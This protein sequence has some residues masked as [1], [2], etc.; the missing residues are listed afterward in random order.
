LRAILDVNSR[1]K[2][3]RHHENPSFAGE[4]S[5]CVQARDTTLV[6]AKKN[7]KCGLYCCLRS[8]SLIHLPRPI[9][10]DPSTWPVCRFTGLVTIKVENGFLRND[11]SSPKS[12]I[13]L[14]QKTTTS[15]N[16]R[17]PSQP[18]S[19]W[20]AVPLA[21]ALAAL[22][23]L[24]KINASMRSVPAEIAQL[25]PH[26]W[27]KE[28]IR[29]TYERLKKQP[30][31]FDKLLPPRLNRR[32]VVVGGSGETSYLTLHLTPHNR[33]LCILTNA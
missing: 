29:E 21:V 17:T 9:V 5:E 14:E 2:H 25:S 31:G 26:R 1:S 22:L 32:Y 27:A 23:Y 24:Y 7:A 16:F 13:A 33:A 30:L 3:E 12:L 18:S 20:W 8:L 4:L 28:E 19:M 10:L 15:P 11:S 6:V